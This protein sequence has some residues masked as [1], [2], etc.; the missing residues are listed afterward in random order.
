VNG[1]AGRTRQPKPP[2]ASGGYRAAATTSP[3]AGACP[4]VLCANCTRADALALAE[5]PHPGIPIRNL[6]PTDLQ[7]ARWHRSGGEPPTLAAVKV[8]ARASARQV[9]D[10]V[11]SLR[12]MGLLSAVPGSADRR[13]LLLEPSAKLIDEI[14]RHPQ[15]VANI[16]A[17]LG[18]PVA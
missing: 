3:F 10:F 4:R 1:C 5:A 6:L 13:T 12:R 15:L 8:T 14:G 9:A 11:G 2:L 17:L 16:Y 18:E 7:Y